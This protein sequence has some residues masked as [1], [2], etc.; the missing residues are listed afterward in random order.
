MTHR[1]I[2]MT[3]ELEAIYDQTVEFVKKEVQPQGERWEE[4]GRIPREILRQLG[5]LGMLGLRVPESLGGV[6]LGPL[7]SVTGSGARAN[8]RRTRDA[9]R[10]TP[11]SCPRRRA[12]SS[13]AAG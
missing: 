6:G 4:E 1:N 12:S 5:D 2:Y 3:D 7:A 11:R 13:A 9:P 8:P 10:R